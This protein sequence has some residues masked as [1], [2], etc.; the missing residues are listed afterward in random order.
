M[1]FG[2]GLSVTEALRLSGREPALQLR[3]VLREKVERLVTAGR[4]P[5][6]AV[7]RAGQDEATAKYAR[8]ILRTCQRI[9]VFGREEI[10]APDTSTQEIVDRVTSLAEL[11]T[12]DGV[13]VQF[14]LPDGVDETQVVDAIP[15]AKDVD[16]VTRYAMGELFTG[17]TP[18]APATALAVVRLLDFYDIPL[19]GC[20]SAVV[21]RSNIAG[22]P[23]SALLLARHSTVTLCHSR[24]P[25]LAEV[26]RRADI[27]V[28]AVGVKHLVGNDYVKPGAV[29]VDVG[30]NYEDDGVYGDVDPV[31]VSPVASALSPV[32]G[33]V[34]P[35]T[36]YCLLATLM[37]LIHRRWG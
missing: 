6:L 35:L 4:L 24:T 18:L 16:R 23:V 1:G 19:S 10:L 12:V 5:T 31:A 17:V 37:T 32:P 3:D 29:V 2:T 14:P 21:G 15:P 34:G 25:D 9:G 27:L 20:H 30:T 11:E 28:V 7:V 36:N 8:Q 33:G 22:K 13:M 26:T